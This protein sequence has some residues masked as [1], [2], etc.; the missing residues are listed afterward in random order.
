ME[1][2]DHFTQTQLPA[3]LLHLQ[4]LQWQQG[5]C[6]C[7]HSL[8]LYSL[9]ILIALSLSHFAL[10]RMPINRQVWW[11]LFFNNSSCTWVDTFVNGGCNYHWQMVTLLLRVGCPIMANPN[12]HPLWHLY[13]QLSSC[14]FSTNLYLAALPSLPFRERLWPSLQV[15]AKPFNHQSHQST[16]F[17]TQKDHYNIWRV[18]TL[19]FG[20]HCIPLRAY[21]PCSVRNDSSSLTPRLTTPPQTEISISKC[22]SHYVSI[23]IW[24][25]AHHS[26]KS[27]LIQE[28]R[29]PSVPL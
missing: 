28:L 26:S 21:Q 10:S 29:L 6:H 19:V 1:E 18:L 16:P 12:N 2:E 7:S 27:L 15:L 14:F 5:Y 13:G 23:S 17:L 3:L 11:L 4:L 22:D 9:H 25:R 24:S 20:T 8:S